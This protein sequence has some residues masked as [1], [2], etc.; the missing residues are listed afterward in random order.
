MTCLEELRQRA[1]AARRGQ[2]QTEAMLD[3]VLA[4][5]GDLELAEV[6]RRIVS[7]A[8]ALV[9]ARYGALGVLGPDRSHLMEFV[10]H[11]LSDQ[12]SRLIGDPPRGH[13]ILGLLIRDPRPCRI[14]DISAHPESYGFPADHPPMASFLGAPV[15]IRGEVYGNL[16]LTEKQD[17][18][19][20][21]DADEALLVALAAAAGV[22]LHNARLYEQSELQRNWSLAVSEVTQSL[23]QSG[24]ESR[25]LDVMAQRVCRVSGA[26]ACV[27]ALHQEGSDHVIAAGHGLATGAGGAETRGDATLGPGTLTGLHWAA[28]L[29]AARPL[30]LLPDLGE[31][32]AQPIVDDVRSMAGLPQ[33][34]PTALIPIT[35]GSSV[36]GV[37]LP[38]WRPAEADIASA[39]V[40]P[41]AE[42]AQQVGIALVA[43]RAQKDLATVL[44][45]E[46]RERIARDMHDLVIQR[47]FA[48]GLSLQVAGRLAQHPVVR[49]RLQEAI[50]ELDS[51]ITDT[52]QIIYQ[53]HAM[54]TP[55]GV[56]ERVAQLVDGYSET[57]G[58]PVGLST[59]E[60]VGV[61]PGVEMDV[62]AVVREGLANV[63]R[64]ARASSATVTLTLGP[65]VQVEI[66]DD[67]VGIGAVTRRIGLANLRDRAAAR[68]GHCEVAPVQPHGTRITWT[69]PVAGHPDGSGPGSSARP[70]LSPPDAQR[71]DRAA[72]PPATR[73]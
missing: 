49:G 6:L 70:G 19:E 51:A 2:E 43:S 58:F 12:V 65:V 14:A 4:I 20:F 30:L 60:P 53:L 36:I 41:L 32:P 3:A 7:S 39:T 47:L 61:E 62:L 45:L 10:K 46:D 68:S 56:A 21:S 63:V 8:C 13:G 17:G 31:A 71:P 67:G 42:F 37:L 24:Q 33:G 16:Y 23:L 35:A 55:T 18:T 59:S 66:V 29:D 27:V 15:R 44:L 22:A 11:G 72:A 50:D 9:G 34:G 52:R 5:S 1:G 38:V 28:A 48:T 40:E 57:L 54:A 69:A 25:A 64:H 73:R 26:S